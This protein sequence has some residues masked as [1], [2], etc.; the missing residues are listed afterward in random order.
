MG[1][2]S[3]KVVRKTQLY[4]TYQNTILFRAK[5]HHGDT[6]ITQLYRTNQKIQFWLGRKSTKLAQK[7]QLYLTYQNTFLVGAKIHQGGTKNA[8]YVSK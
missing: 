3:T 2:K 6:K 8:A 5:I 7:T 1:R 4:L